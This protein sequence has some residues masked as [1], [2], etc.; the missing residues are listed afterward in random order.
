[1][2]HAPEV[3]ATYESL[4]NLLVTSSCGEGE[5]HGP[6]SGSV[7]RYLIAYHIAVVTLDGALL[8]AQTKAAEKLVFTSKQGNVT[9]D[10]AA[11]VN[12]QER[13]HDLPR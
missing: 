1:L 7:R 13:L 11:H 12:R 10:H 5:H 3:G 9:F 2:S 8:L 6:G 4:P